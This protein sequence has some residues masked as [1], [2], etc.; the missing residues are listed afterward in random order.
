VTQLLSD[1]NEGR[2]EA[3]DRLMP[4]VYA[5]LRRLADGCL[6]SERSRH[7]LQAT[8]LVNEAYMRLVGA[9]HPEYENRTQ[10]FRIAGRVMRQILV[11]YAQA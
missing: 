8:A 2:Q 1:L 7:T 4:V 5:E 11:D 6:R 9:A 3:L 10:F